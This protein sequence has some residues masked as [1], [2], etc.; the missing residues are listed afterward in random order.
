MERADLRGA[1]TTNAEFQNATNFIGLTDEQW[2]RLGL[3]T[4]E[5]LDMFYTMLIEKMKNGRGAAGNG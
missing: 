4:A 2:L 1:I 3:L 5:E